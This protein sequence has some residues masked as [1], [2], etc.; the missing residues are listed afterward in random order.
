MSGCLSS[1]KMAEKVKKKEVAKSIPTPATQ[2]V[3]H[4]CEFNNIN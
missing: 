1:N 2:N 3:E 4:K